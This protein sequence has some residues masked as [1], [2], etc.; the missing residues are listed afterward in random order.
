MFLKSTAEIQG[1]IIPDHGGDFAYLVVFALQKVPGIG[2]AQG[3]N[4]LCRSIAGVLLKISGKPT[5]A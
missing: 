1:V 5:G 2:D 3:G 4:I